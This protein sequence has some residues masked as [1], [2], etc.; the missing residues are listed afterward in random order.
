MIIL[1][2]RGWWTDPSEKN[3]RLAISKAFSAGFGVET[4]VRD[5]NGEL[6]LSHDMPTDGDLTPFEWVVSSFASA[7][8]PGYLAI[9]IKADGLHAPLIAML[10]RHGVTRAFV[11]DMAVPDAVG[12]LKARISSFTRHSEMEP[13]PP[14]Y[15]R[16]DGVWMD[17]FDTDWIAASDVKTHLDAGKAVALVSPEL[18]GRNPRSAWEAWAPLRDT[19]AMICTDLPEQ[20]LASV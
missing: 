12:Y 4:D 20:W 11:F 9:N 6:V 8:Q 7:G 3:S 2:H 13:A 18:H 14:F 5:H 17:C 15:E 16:A 1:A 10:A 19:D